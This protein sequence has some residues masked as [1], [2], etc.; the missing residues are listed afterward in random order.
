MLTLL[1]RRRPDSAQ[2]PRAAPVLVLSE[3]LERQLAAVQACTTAKRHSFGS[4]L[5]YIVLT[6]AG[7]IAGNLL[8]ILGCAVAMFIVISHARIDMFFLHIDNLASRYVAA[9]MGRRAGFEHQL[10]QLF[11]IAC[12]LTLLVRGP[13]F[14][15][16]LRRELGRGR[17]A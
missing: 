10:V 2:V 5:A 11:I 15:A 7:W 12:A 14:V 8:A 17:Q 16:R 1:S 4:D 3:G 9:D 13:L 6:T